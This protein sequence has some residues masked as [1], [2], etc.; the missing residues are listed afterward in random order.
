MFGK[1]YISSRSRLSLWV[2]GAVLGAAALLCSRASADPTEASPAP[3]RPLAISDAPPVE[4]PHTETPPAD[5]PHNDP[6]VVQAGCSSCSSGLW[7]AAMGTSGG[8]G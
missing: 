2:L 6:N 5:A 1:P 3:P 8:C 7:G 4:K